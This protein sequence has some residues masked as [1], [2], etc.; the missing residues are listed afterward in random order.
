MIFFTSFFDFPDP[1]LYR[2][3]LNFDNIFQFF[4]SLKQI[5]IKLNHRRKTLIQ[6]SILVAQKIEKKMNL[7]EFPIQNWIRKI[8]SLIFLTLGIPGPDFSVK[9]NRSQAEADKS[10]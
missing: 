4:E 8:N 5:E 3:I 10:R 6:L 1:V 2:G 7:Q 9:G